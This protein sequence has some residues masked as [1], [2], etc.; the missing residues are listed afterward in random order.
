MGGA[1]EEYTN[2]YGVHAEGSDLT[3]KFV[4]QGPYSKNIGSR[5]FLLEDESTYKL[6]QLKN[7]EFA[8]DVDVSKLPCGLNGA[9]YFVE[10]DADGGKGRYPGNKAGAKYGTGYCDAQCPHDIKFINGEANSEDWKPSATD[11]NAGVGKYGTCCTEFDVWEANSMGE[12]YTA[13]ACNVASQF[14][15]EGTACGD[16][17]DDRFKGV[18]DKNGCDFQTYR[19]G[20]KN[21]WGA[22][23]SFDIDT[24]QPMTSVTQF[25]THDGTDDGDLV[26][27]RRFYKQNGKLVQTPS[28]SVGGKGP[29]H[30]LSKD[31]CEAEVGLFQDHTNFLD[32][33]GFQVTDASFKKG[34]V[35]ALSLWDD[36]YA[37]MLWLDSTYPKGST[38][39]GDQRGPCSASS[40]VPSNVESQHADATVKY[41]NIKYGELGSTTSDDSPS[42]GPSPGPSPSGCP[43]GSLSACMNLCPTDPTAFQACVKVCES[44]CSGNTVVV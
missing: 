26:E 9:L 6:F 41:Y 30:S 39:P 31:Y 37:N 43:G 33:G 8:F 23:S 14:R 29:Y 20:N 24:T 21:F 1:D 18:C 12:A 38:K 42:P 32:K 3:L 11:P 4:T 40:G 17:G 13:H 28:I 15:C 25:I 16:N 19:L 36:H 34:M 10:I 7:K 35:L 2:T 44:K 5:V 27:I 22:G